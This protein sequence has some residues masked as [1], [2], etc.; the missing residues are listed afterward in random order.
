MTSGGKFRRLAESL[1]F[2]TLVLIT[3]FAFRYLRTELDA[4]IELLRD[5]LTR[6]AEEILGSTVTYDSI[7][8]SILRYFEVR[9]FRLQS[10]E[11]PDET[12]LQLSRIRIHYRLFRFLFEGDLLASLTE[13]SVENSRL[14]LDT[15]RDHE[16]MA[17]INRML[18]MP[19]VLY[20]ITMS[21]K[22]LSINL[23]TETGT[24]D[25]KDLFFSV[26][27]EGENASFTL[28]RG[29]IT[30]H[31]QGSPFPLTADVRLKGHLGS[32]LRWFDSEVR[33]DS[34][35]SPLFSLSR[36]TFQV[37]Y[38]AD[39]LRVNKI[40]DKSPLDLQFIWKFVSDEMELTFAA[41]NADPSRLISLQGLWA[42]WNDWLNAS[43][44]GGGSLTFRPRER[45]AAYSM[46][47]EGTV[48]P[49][50][51]RSPVSFISAVSGTEDRIVFQP[52]AVDS[53]MGSLL[54]KGDILFVN[55]LPKG[56][57]KLT[58]V[59]TSIGQEISAV[60]DIDREENGLFLHGSYLSFGDIDFRV[61]RAG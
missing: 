30:V 3:G 12:L 51:R 41:E 39:V 22:Q 11:H 20:P 28:K 26:A 32:D 27:H 50:D 47:L 43:V 42:P 60:I 59:S 49:P 17:I 55:F 1:L 58:G 61:T 10:A 33:I 52:L 15:H 25:V 7:A 44:S 4:R 40:R 46:N 29:K 56:W 19:P 2:S 23:T 16:L 53:E 36:Q 45:T 37:I 31:R 21:G 57:L 13:I 9:N 14:T 38:L 18:E 48:I 5:Q 8:P 6:T 34:L 54:F 35:S 24:Y